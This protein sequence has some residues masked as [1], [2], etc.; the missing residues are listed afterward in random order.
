MLPDRFHH[1]GGYKLMQGSIKAHHLEAVSPYC[2]VTQLH[3][4]LRMWLVGKHL[5]QNLQSDG[6]SRPGSLFTSAW[7]HPYQLDPN[8]FAGLLACQIFVKLT[9]SPIRFFFWIYFPM[10]IVYFL[11]SIN[12]FHRSEHLVIDLF[13]DAVKPLL[14]CC[15]LQYHFC[16]TWRSKLKQCFFPDSGVRRFH[17]LPRPVSRLPTVSSTFLCQF[18]SSADVCILS[19]HMV[20]TRQPARASASCL[21]HL[22]YQAL[23]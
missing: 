5:R 16:K 2:F 17:K 14:D 9:T 22:Q 19:Q 23:Q 15:A 7:N 10:K 18:A 11:S 21:N 4:N 1:F 13:I 3:E 8:H 12:S 6:L 20:C